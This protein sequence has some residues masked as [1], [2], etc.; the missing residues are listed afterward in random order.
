MSSNKH[1]LIAPETAL[2][3]R[4]TSITPSLPHA[5][6]GTILND[7]KPNNCSEI[8]IGMGC[9]WG[10]N[11]Y[12]GIGQASIV[13]LLVIVVVSLRTLPMR[14]FAR[15]KQGIQKLSELFMIL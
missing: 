8:I 12:F 9:F 14:K 15:V 3:G 10:L 13:Q 1:N 5:V 2:I 7:D 4:A 11:A 6:N